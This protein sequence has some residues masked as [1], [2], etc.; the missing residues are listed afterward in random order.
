MFVILVGI[1]LSWIVSLVGGKE[2]VFIFLIMGII[3]VVLFMV[4]VFIVWLFIWECE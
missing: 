3:F 4:V 2:L 1:L